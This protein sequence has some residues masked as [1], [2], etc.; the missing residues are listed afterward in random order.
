[1]RE[2]TEKAVNLLC[3]LIETPSYSGEE[4]DTAKIL[5]DYLEDNGYKPHQK[6]NNVWAFSNHF[7]DKKST[8]LL[9]SHH[10]TVHATMKWEN[11]PFVA[12]LLDGKLTGLSLIHISEPTRPY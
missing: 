10:D 9:N 3:R 5:S 8:I 2:I 4:H 6:G 12:N 1:M 11:N 7:D